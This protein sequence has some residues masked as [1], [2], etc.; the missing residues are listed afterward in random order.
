MPGRADLPSTLLRSPRKAQDTWVAADDSALETY[1]PGCREQQ[2]AYA[3]VKH[4]FEKV[5]DRWEPKERRGP[6]DAQ[7][8]GGAGKRE[9]P[10]R[11]GVDRSRGNR[12]G[13]E[14]TAA[15][16]TER[17]REGP[18]RRR[19]SGAAPVQGRA[20]L[21]LP[22]GRCRQCISRPSSPTRAGDTSRR[23]REEKDLLSKVVRD[24]PAHR[25]SRGRPDVG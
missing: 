12:A 25:R 5:G 19:A 16:R 14:S 13:A 3:A 11:G 24:E 20:R 6:S 8:A 9:R 21:R 17:Q 22:A 4:S 18:E 1:G 23:T 10:T 7:V 15:G 2:T